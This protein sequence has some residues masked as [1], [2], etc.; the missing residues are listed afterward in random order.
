MNALTRAAV[1]GAACALMIGAVLLVGGR[2]WRP[3]T[4]RSRRTV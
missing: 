1:Q 4:L 3:A 2:V